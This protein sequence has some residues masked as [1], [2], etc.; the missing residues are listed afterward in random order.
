MGLLRSAAVLAAALSTLLVAPG[1]ATAERGVVAGPA[2]GDCHTLTVDEGAKPSDPDPT[3]SCT[4]THTSI[5]IRVVQLSDPD[6]SDMN[7]LGRKIST[8]CYQGLIDELG[9]DTKKVQLSAYSF[10]WF[11][12]TKAERDSGASWVRCDAVLL[13]GRKFVSL[14]SGTD[15]SLG[16]L[17]L[18]DKLAKCRAGKRAN[19]QVISCSKSHA[20]HAKLALKYPGST[21]PGKR[22][23]ERWALRHCRAHLDRTFY[24][25]AVESKFAWNLGYRYAICLP[26]TRS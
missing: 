16:S 26:E 15:I 6:W 2:V 4:D 9:G 12:P 10:F 20:F 1:S 8:P 5:T 17:P 23:A 13:G 3:V 11:I 21:Y 19:Y 18:G 7:A 25:E 24:Y 22:A 14:P